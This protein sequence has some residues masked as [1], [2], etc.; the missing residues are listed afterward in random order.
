ML[1]GL[2]RL[3]PRSLIATGIFFVTALISANALGGGTI[4]PPCPPGQP[5]YTPVYPSTHNLI[6]MSSTVLVSGLINSIVVPR[7]LRPSE[8]SRVVFSYISGLQ[9]GLG[10]IITGMADP[11]K[12]L[13]FFSWTDLSNF[14]PSL[15][16]VM[17]FGV[18]PNILSYLSL[19][20]E[21]DQ[22]KSPTLAPK[23]RL[24]TATVA[25]I[26]WRF[27]A[28]AVAFGVGWGLSGVCPGPG[29]LRS[30][31]QPSWGVPWLGG[32]LSGSLVG[33]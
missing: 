19:R 24:P 5:C 15:A 12:V 17:L 33:L 13:R 3:S 14:D 27:V 28:G 20:G 32:F 1:C 16:L 9:F 4:I 8:R 10:L 2:S 21:I 11:A 30:V 22:K 31:M 29:L 7:M 26:D 23:F 18:G 6:F 25:D